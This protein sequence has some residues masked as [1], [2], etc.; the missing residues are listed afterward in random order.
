MDTF[1]LKEPLAMILTVEY[2]HKTLPQIVMAQKIET[3]GFSY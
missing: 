3:G 2:K 1:I